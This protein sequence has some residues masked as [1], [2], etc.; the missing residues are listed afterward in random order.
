M[1]ISPLLYGGLLT[2]VAVGY[3]VVD[4]QVLALDRLID[5]MCAEFREPAKARGLSFVQQLE[6]VWVEADSKA[7]ARIARN[8]IDNA[9]KYTEVGTVQVTVAKGY[10]AA[11]F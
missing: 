8:L 2:I 1:I 4:R 6:S 3:Y 9:I 11:P 7:V 10:G 5:E